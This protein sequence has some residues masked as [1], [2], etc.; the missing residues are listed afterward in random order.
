[1]RLLF[2]LGNSRLKWAF[3]ENGI[4][5]SGS[6]D[7]HEL[8]LLADNLDKAM[9]S[10]EAPDEAWISSVAGEKA[11]G[12]LKDWLRQ[13]WSLEG[14]AITVNSQVHDLAN[15]Y[16]QP[17]SLGSDRWAALV[18]VRHRYTQPASIIDCGTA[19]TIDFI[20]NNRFYGGVILPGLQLARNSLIASTAK[21][22]LNGSQPISSISTSTSAGILSGT[23][24]GL[25]GA[26]EHIVKQ[27]QQDTGLSPKIYLTGGN[28]NAIQPYL[29]LANEV[30]DD[31]VLQG[32]E[33]IAELEA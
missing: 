19:V 25:V 16:V 29:A 3:S 27:Q 7:A 28:A 14:R 15:A 4:Q 5:K 8:S 13:R 11:T 22:Q 9:T 6:L 30:V 17:E 10:T 23:L 1:M 31:L 21:L 26:I 12:K 18:A 33:V 2:D 24:L 32:M 20:N